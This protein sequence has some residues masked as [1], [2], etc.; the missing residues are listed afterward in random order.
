MKVWSVVVLL[1]KR[2]LNS[3]PWCLLVCNFVVLLVVLEWTAA[4]T[5]DRF[6]LFLEFFL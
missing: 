3:L 1:L 4:I 5:G 2:G 6:G